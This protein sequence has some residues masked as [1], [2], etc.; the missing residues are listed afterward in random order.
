[1]GLAG[2]G[3]SF[4]GFYPCSSPAYITT[5]PIW[6]VNI[7]SHCPITTANLLSTYYGPS[8]MLSASHAYSI[9]ISCLSVVSERSLSEVGP[10][11][12]LFYRW[13]NGST[14]RESTLSTG[15]WLG[16]CEQGFEHQKPEF[17]VQMLRYFATLVKPGGGAGMERQWGWAWP[18]PSWCQ[19]CGFRS[20]LVW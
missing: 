16:N 8:T 5:Q 10:W 14:G 7:L 2:M 20:L 6:R 11:S 9:Y 17:R 13:G 1:M 12:A 3:Q 4:Q 15:T 19:P 18:L